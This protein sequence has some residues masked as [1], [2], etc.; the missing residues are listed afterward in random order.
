[1]EST[2]GG[3][4]PKGPPSKK[5]LINLDSEEAR[6]ELRQM[7]EWYEVERIR[8]APN[9]YQQAID[10][11]FYDGLQWADEDAQELAL[12]GQAPLVYNKIQPAVKWLTGTEKRTRIDY[13][14]LPRKHDGVNEAENKTK[15]MKYLE[16]V[17]KGA[18]ARSR[19]FE[20]CVKVG[21]GWLECGI[22][23]D[24]TMELLYSRAESWRNVIYDSQ[25]WEYDL[26]DA[27]YQF[28]Q[29]WTDLD[30]AQALFPKRTAQLKSASVY[31][32]YSDA[33]DNE[34]WYLGQILQERAADGS[35]MN[36]RTFV[37]T[38]S[39]LFNRR[40]RVKLMEC[41]YRKPE[42]IDYIDSAGSVHHNQ[43][44]DKDN[45]EHVALLNRPDGGSL[46]QR[47]GMRMWCAIYIRG[48]LLQWMRS[49][50]KHNDFPF[51]PVWGNRRARDHAPYGVVRVARDP[52]EDFNKRMSKALY[53]L[54]TRRIIMDHG[55]VDDIE[56]LRQ[57]A[58]RPD[59]IIEKNKGY[60]LE[61]TTD[62]D[63]AD[64]HLAYA[65]LDEKA[66]QDISGVTDE[67]MGHKTNA[68]SGRAIE[69]RQDQG[70]T[71]TT[72][73][74][75]NLRLARQL[76]GQ[77]ELSLI[78]QYYTEEKEIRVI[79]S[80]RPDD[81]ITLN[82]VE[83]DGSIIND[84]TQTEC[85]FIVDETDYKATQR[86]AMFDAMLEQVG[87]I[88]K[89][90]PQWGM[91]MLDDVLEFSDV[92]GTD[93]M[94]A[95]IR[96]LIGK[97]DPYKVLT[98]EEQQAQ[99]QAEQQAAQ[100]ANAQKQLEFSAAK[101][102][103]DT[104]NAKATEIMARA[105]LLDAQA[106]DLGVPDG[107]DQNADLAASYNE[108]VQK[109]HD[110]TESTLDQLRKE[111]LELERQLGAAN[112]RAT[113]NQRTVDAN[114]QLG[115]AKIASTERIAAM[116]DRTLEATGKNDRAIEGLKE[117]EQKLSGMLADLKK[118]KV[119]KP[120]P[121]E[122]AQSM[123]D[124][125]N[126]EIATKAKDAKT[127]EAIGKVK[128]TANTPDPRIDKLLEGMGKIHD[129]VKELHEKHS[130]LEQRVK[131]KVRSK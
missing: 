56:E 7:E 110:D 97:A 78:K 60:E 58:A 100:E 37:D 8:Q 125:H 5:A 26:S 10:D 11:D 33:Q 130:A 75:D 34:E 3:E 107:S 123:I 108:Q 22:R 104:L 72:D 31:S 131:P 48:T 64:H 115:Y 30:I 105:R 68:V 95:S 24:P 14:I 19:A 20:E 83:P 79:G 89:V 94:V 6:R 40:S 93:Q 66:I 18:Y 46:Y 81:F 120:T 126:D 103:A 1:M 98:P 114:L 101:G 77:K 91:Y 121:Q 59:A 47:M 80:H 9:R 65:N 86:Q 96:K 28:R 74:F 13:K 111:I 17:N 61:M 21:I 57:E 25:A 42:S 73:F 16:D 90:N 38:S 43:P 70:S 23:G 87:E 35:V 32:D 53:A 71:V 92:P 99:A 52:Q 109:L 15:L 29:K 27:R 106:A 67:L 128:E 54:S 2:L 76:H 82:K 116:N 117:Q 88:M 55:A 127:K 118:T 112:L 124:D 44:Y 41:W 102:K 12:R 36:R 50:Y 84:V 63:I 122:E 51:T 85:D 129:S 39:S 119:D 49:P 62:V 4:P 45:A 113:N 69:K